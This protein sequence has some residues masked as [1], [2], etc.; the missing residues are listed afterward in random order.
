LRAL[1]DV[2]KPSMDQRADRDRGSL[3]QS[4]H[5]FLQERAVLAM[6]R[7]KHAPSMDHRA[8]RDRGSLLQ[9][10]HGFL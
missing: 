9:S 3:L 2:L 1:R 4:R 7:V 5:G 10:R 6:P 8:D